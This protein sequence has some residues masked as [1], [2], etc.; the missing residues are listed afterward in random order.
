M[1]TRTKTAC[2][3]V[4]VAAAGSL[5]CRG[6]ETDSSVPLVAGDV[7]VSYETKH[8][9]YGLVDADDPV[10]KPYGELRFLGH[11]SVGSRFFIDT[12]HYG[13]K[14]GRGDC[15]W[16]F[17]EIDFPAYVWHMFRKEDFAWLPTSVRLDAGYRYEYHPPRT[18]YHDTQFWVAD[19]SLPDLW[20]VPTFSYERDTV[21]D[22]GTYLWL[23][24]AHDFAL[25]EGVNL[26]LMVSQ[27][28]GDRKRVR[29]YLPSPDLKGRLDRAGLM[30][31]WLKAS[32]DWAIC[33]N[34]K[35]SVFVAY[36]DFLFDRHIRDAA[37]RYIKNNAGGRGSIHSSWTF[38]VG[39]SVTYSF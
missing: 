13:E 34:L 14:V 3:T 10:F 15:A 2:L 5:A 25:A 23:S 39:I 12:S 9:S 24:L 6:G 19:V 18:G 38:P 35:V 36:V 4:L 26:N 16:D 21:N 32:L 20:L 30:D 28:W 17:W 27:G 8:L 22:D 37:R 7:T 31:T 29:G 11:A 33:E 1:R